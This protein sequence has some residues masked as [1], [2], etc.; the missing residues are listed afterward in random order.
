M[1]Q[2]RDAQHARDMQQASKRA[3][4]DL[5]AA[6]SQLRSQLEHSQQAWH[7]EKA[8]YAQQ[9]TLLQA[10]K[11]MDTLQHDLA[12]ER[13]KV[14]QLTGKSQEIAKAKQDALEA[15][16]ALQVIP[17]EADCTASDLVCPPQH[18]H[19]RSIQQMSA[20]ASNTVQ[21]LSMSHCPALRPWLCMDR[22]SSTI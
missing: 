10:Q 2:D 5:E 3:A 8:Q 7:A 22:E 14:K 4:Q 12:A 21:L 11:H 20:G 9:D 1:L 13:Q 19:T 16:K 15:S 17:T 18:G 6:A